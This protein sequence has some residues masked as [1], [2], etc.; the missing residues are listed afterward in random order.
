MPD[1]KGVLNKGFLTVQDVLE[2]TNPLTTEELADFANRLIEGDIKSIK[3]ELWNKHVSPIMPNPR[4]TDAIH[5]LWVT[6]TR[7]QAKRIIEA[8]AP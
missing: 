5:E 4:N 8:P 2:A 3:K 7:V 1:K 6:V